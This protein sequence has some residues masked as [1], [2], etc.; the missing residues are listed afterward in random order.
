MATADLTLI[1]D[2]QTGQNLA[3][4]IESSVEREQQITQEPIPVRRGKHL[5]VDAVLAR[6]LA[7]VV[8]E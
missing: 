4:A 3:R 8:G 5:D 1:N 2:G 7:R 6:A